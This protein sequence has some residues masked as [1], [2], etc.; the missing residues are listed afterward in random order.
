[1]IY[2]IEKVL[3]E[4]KVNIE[5]NIYKMFIFIVK[6]K[7]KKKERIYLLTNNKVK[8]YTKY[9]KSQFFKTTMKG[10]EKDKSKENKNI[11]EKD[12]NNPTEKENDDNDMNIGDILEEQEEVKDDNNEN[13]IQ[14]KYSNSFTTLDK[15]KENEIKLTGKEQSK[16]T[17]YPKY[18]KKFTLPKYRMKFNESPSILYEE[19]FYIAFGGFWNGDIILR[20]LIDNKIDTKK[21]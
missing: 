7:D 13:E 14:S 5:D 10:K 16:I 12:E 21:K 11:K 3:K 18:D 8:I 19:G 6:K 15:Q 9:D 20:Q 17:V 1:M 4:I 2:V